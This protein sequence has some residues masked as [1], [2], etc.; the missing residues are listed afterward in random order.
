MPRG[1]MSLSSP[2][3]R[4]PHD[5]RKENI[6][7]HIR[8][9]EMVRLA[10]LCAV[11]FNFKESH[12]SLHVWPTAAPAS[13]IWNRHPRWKHESQ[14]PVRIDLHR[15]RAHRG[16]CRRVQVAS[17]EARSHRGVRRS[18][19]GNPV[20]PLELQR[21]VLVIHEHARY[22]DPH[23]P[24]PRLQR[25]TVQRCSSGASCG[26]SETCN[27][28]PSSWSRTPQPQGH[29]DAARSPAGMNSDCAWSPVEN[30]S[31]TRSDRS[32]PSTRRGSPS[33]WRLPVP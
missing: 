21:L 26:D 20:L 10:L 31:Q 27:V 22:I 32:C 11:Q 13:T 25:A 6:P 5:T 28:P 19:S 30:R 4:R 23:R 8:P 15:S 12:R 24:L 9:N 2:P 17:C 29:R 1:R 18:S 3:V 33:S 7:G 14:L 16:V